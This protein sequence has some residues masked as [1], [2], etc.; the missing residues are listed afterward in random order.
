MNINQNNAM[1][2]QPVNLP[3]QNSG[4]SYTVTLL[5][6]YFV[7]GLGVDRMYLGYVGLGI[8]K[9]FTLGGLGIWAIV[10][11]V[12]IIL[13]KIKPADGSDYID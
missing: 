7:G 8:L 9:L 5:L 12:L 2:Q 10:D 13:K 11:A 3:Q 4:K 1:N 6:T